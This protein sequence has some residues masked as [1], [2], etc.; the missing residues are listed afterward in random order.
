MKI[1]IANVNVRNQSGTSQKTGK[2]YSMNKQEAYLH[3]DGQPY[4]VRFEFNL[5]DGATPFQKGFYTVT[6]KSFIVD[7]FGSLA[8][9]GQL[10]LV[11]V[12]AGQQAR[13]AA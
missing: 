3:L 1:E 11:P 7:R 8:L 6:D 5:A 4:P 9:S 2:P 10:E 13:P 12:V